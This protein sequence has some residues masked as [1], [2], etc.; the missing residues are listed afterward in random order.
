[1]FIKVS[2]LAFRMLLF[3]SHDN[4]RIGEASFSAV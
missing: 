3:N 1:M 4:A 2:V